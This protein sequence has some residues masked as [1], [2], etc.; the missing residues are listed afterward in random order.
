MNKENRWATG[1]KVEIIDKDDP[2]FG[3]KGVLMEAAKMPILM[4]ELGSKAFSSSEEVY[5]MVKLEG[6]ETPRKFN[7]NQLRKT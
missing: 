3:N 5:W 7:S 1:D 6:V 2:D 4:K